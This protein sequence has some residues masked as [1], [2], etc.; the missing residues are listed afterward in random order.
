[1]NNTWCA[2]GRE[3][4]HPSYYYYCYYSQLTLLLH[5]HICVNVGDYAMNTLCRGATSYQLFSINNRFSNKK[6][7]EK[8]SSASPRIGDG[9]YNKHPYKYGRDSRRVRRDRMGYD[10]NGNK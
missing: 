5:E 1:M 6:G 2:G 9:G 10:R 8:F 4:Y 3:L 7:N